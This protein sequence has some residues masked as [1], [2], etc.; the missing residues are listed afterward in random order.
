[1]H[2]D[3]VVAYA[4]RQLKPY[5]RNY[6]THDLKLVAEIFSLKIMRHFLFGDVKPE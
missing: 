2:D 6:P 5:E 1:M 4:S 3:K